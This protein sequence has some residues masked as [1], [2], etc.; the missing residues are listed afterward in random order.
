M[1]Y[2]IKLKYITLLLSIIIALTGCGKKTDI[3]LV[4]VDDCPG[5]C[6][7]GGVCNEDTGHCDCPEG[8]TGVLCQF[9]VNPCY[10]V[11]CLNGGLCVGCNRILM[12][13]LKVLF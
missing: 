4:G 8:Y 3:I 13:N 5:V 10:M 6:E 11:D 12:Y 2:I 9:E 1:N 7:N